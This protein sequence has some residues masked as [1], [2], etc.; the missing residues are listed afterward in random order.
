[1]DGIEIREAREDDYGGLIELLEAHAKYHADML[2]YYFR[3]AQQRSI[4]LD[5]IAK[6]NDP[7]KGKIVAAFDGG[8]IVGI[9]FGMLDKQTSP[10]AEQEV[11]G[12]VARAYVLESYRGKGIGQALFKSLLEWFKAKGVHLLIVRAVVGNDAA[13]GAWEKYGFKL[14]SYTY[15]MLI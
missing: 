3:A 4:W 14:Q 12:I 7:E 2:P 8:K 15:D 9:F 6:Y 10:I 13:S 1:M 11:V 5:Y